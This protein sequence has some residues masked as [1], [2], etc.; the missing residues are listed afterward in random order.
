MIS[1]QAHHKA[2]AIFRLIL[3][4]FILGLLPFSLFSQSEGGLNFTGQDSAA[5]ELFIDQLTVQE[6]AKIKELKGKENKIFREYYKIRLEYMNYLTDSE[7]FVFDNTMY[8]K[9]NEILENIKELNPEY[10][11]SNANRVLVGNSLVPNAVC[12]GNE[13]LVVYLGLL[14]LCENE[15]QLAFV[16][17][18]EL[19]HQILDHVDNTLRARIAHRE[20]RELLEKKKEY[21]KAEDYNKSSIANEYNLEHGFK[22]R[23]ESRKKE[24]QADSLAYV[25]LENTSY[26]N[27]EAI[28]FLRILDNSDQ[29]KYKIA[30]NLD[31][32]L[33][34]T[35]Q[36]FN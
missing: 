3:S 22:V 7:S 35:N 27:N 12:Y 28:R 21:K 13:V 34:G 19:S 29:E 30:L 5:A 2:F 10:Q 20:S 31:S 25:L 8:P 17:A 1:L 9:L 36:K 6:E 33:N 18:H 26:N 4:F 14:A 32:I 11:L 15:S 24:S 16:I 23:A